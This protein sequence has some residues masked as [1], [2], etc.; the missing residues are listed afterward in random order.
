VAKN[1][2][3]KNQEEEKQPRSTSGGAKHTRS[4]KA[5]RATQPPQPTRR[6][7]ATRRTTKQRT[8]QNKTE[9]TEEQQHNTHETHTNQ[10]HTKQQHH[11]ISDRATQPN[12]QPKEIHTRDNT[13]HTKHPTDHKTRTHQQQPANTRRELSHNAE[14]TAK[15]TKNTQ[16][17]Q[18]APAQHGETPGTTASTTKM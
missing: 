8:T 15:A 9:P 11:K 10:P 2:K 7:T 18:K 5:D 6:R 13:A 12:N 14:A 16:L 4:K 3:K 17:P 1:V